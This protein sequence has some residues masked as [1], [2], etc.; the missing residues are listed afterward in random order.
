[1]TQYTDATNTGVP[2][3]PIKTESTT[4]ETE[5]VESLAETVFSHRLD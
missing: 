1:M 5:T 2:A 3:V 4:P